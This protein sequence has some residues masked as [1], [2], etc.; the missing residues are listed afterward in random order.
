MRHLKM[1]MFHTMIVPLVLV[2]VQWILDNDLEGNRR[3][4]VSIPL[5]SVSLYDHSTI[6]IYTFHR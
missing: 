1:S 5:V 3:R 4:Q 6:I 2:S